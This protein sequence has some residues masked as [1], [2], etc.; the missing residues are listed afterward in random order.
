MVHS[1]QVKCP[2][3]V[4]HLAR[5]V[6]NPRNRDGVTWVMSVD[7]ITC[8][9][10]I[11]SLFLIAHKMKD[12]RMDIYPKM[13]SMRS[14]REDKTQKGNIKGKNILHGITQYITSVYYNSKFLNFQDMHL[15]EGPRLPCGQ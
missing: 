11:A 12:V 5:H 14:M 13:R 2:W 15:D 9:V 10:R 3:Q 1:D 4:N 8:F 7:S 6:P